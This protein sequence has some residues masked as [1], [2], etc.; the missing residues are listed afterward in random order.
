M[1]DGKLYRGVKLADSVKLVRVNGEYNSKIKQAL[2]RFIDMLEEGGHELLSE[3]TGNGIKVLIN[4]NCGHEPLWVKPNSYING[5]RCPKCYEERRGSINKLHIKAKEEF[6]LIVEENGHVLLSEYTTALGKVLIDFKCGHEPSWIQPNKYKDRKRCPRCAR[7]TKEQGYEEL[8]SLMEKNGHQLLSEYVSAH[9]KVLIDYKCG[10]DPSWITPSSYR[11]GSG[12]YECGKISMAKTLSTYS[13]EA[14]L[15]LVEENGHVLLSEYVRND[16][17]VLIDFKC[18]HEPN[19]ITPA[20]Y[21][22]GARCPKCSESKGEKIIREWLEEQGIKYI[23]QYSFPSDYRKYDFILPFENTIIE[24]HGLQHYEEIDYF[25]RRGGRTLAEE[26][27]NDRC[28]EEYAKEMG[29]NYI[30]VDYREHDPQLALQRFIHAYNKLKSEYSITP[31]Q[32]GVR[33]DIMNDVVKREKRWRLTEDEV[34]DIRRRLAAGER[35]SYLAKL[36]GMEK[37]AITRIK[38]RRSW[39]HIE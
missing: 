15:I 8:I 26:Q 27:A 3:Y 4:F 9:K 31:L 30:V 2:D 7:N 21:K 23:A 28:K 22:H 25:A 14:F 10:H 29:F 24:V 39:K 37:T 32:K 11:K 38:Y 6:P 1:S 5:S 33:I 35:V 13:K 12:C 36:Y 20:N 34:R 17:K 18:G 19:W 16:E